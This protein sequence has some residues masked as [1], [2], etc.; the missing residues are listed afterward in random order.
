MGIVETENS[1]YKIFIIYCFVCGGNKTKNF[2]LK[3]FKI[4][5]K[6]NNNQ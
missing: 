4:M 5:T 2:M 1:E 3:L 6:S